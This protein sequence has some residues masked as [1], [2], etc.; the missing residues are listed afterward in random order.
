MS[1]ILN[2]LI[3]TLSVGPSFKLAASPVWCLLGIDW[4]GDRKYSHGS[5]RRWPL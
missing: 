5:N 1:C 3:N 4:S 2:K